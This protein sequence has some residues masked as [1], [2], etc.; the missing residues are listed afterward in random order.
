MSRDLGVICERHAEAAGGSAGLGCV[1][2]VGDDIGGGGLVEGLG[3]VGLLDGVI[4][5]GV[6]VELALDDRRSHSSLGEEIS[7]VVAGAADADGG[8]VGGGEEVGGP[9]LRGEA[10]SCEKQERSRRAALHPIA[11]ATRG[12][13]MISLA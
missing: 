12:S 7:P 5:D 3:G 1:G 13:V 9:I 11:E 6:G 2:G 8:D 4:A 10:R